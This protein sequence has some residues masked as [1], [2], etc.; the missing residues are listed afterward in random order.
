[1]AGPLNLAALSPEEAALS[2]QPHL[3]KPSQ[4]KDGVGFSVIYRD[5]GRAWNV[6]DEHVFVKTQYRYYCHPLSRL[7]FRMPMLR[8]ELIALRK[9]HRVGIDVPR[10]IFY[11]E[12]GDMTELVISGIAGSFPLNEALDLSAANRNLIIEN[13][14]RVIGSLHR[15]GWTHGALGNEHLL[16]QPELQC[17]VNLIDLEKARPGR[18]RIKKDLARFLRNASCFS[19]TETKHFLDCYSLVLAG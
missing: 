15:H 1:M 14:A 6:G 8:R 13:T 18:W 17:R 19:Q 12:L 11:R 10:V 5:Q 16:V 9:C 4:T 2:R 3:M 7:G